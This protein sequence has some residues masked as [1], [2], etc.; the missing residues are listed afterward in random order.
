MGVERAMICSP[1]FDFGHKTPIERGFPASRIVLPIL[2][3][4][5]VKERKQETSPPKLLDEVIVNLYEQIEKEIFIP[6][7]RTRTKRQLTREFNN[8]FEEYFQLR[9]S[10]ISAF[11]SSM[12][13]E[14][15]TTRLLESAEKE[16]DSFFENE[17]KKYLGEDAALSVMFALETRKKFKNGFLE[18]INKGLIN[19][20][21]IEK[22]I[23]TLLHIEAFN[24]VLDL[25][26][27]SLILALRTK[28]TFDV[29]K[30]I[31]KELA[32]LSKMASTMLYSDAKKLE[33]IKYPKPK[34]TEPIEIMSDD[35]DKYLAE[36]G[37][38][39]Y[40]TIL[41]REEG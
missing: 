19:D 32:S 29:K 20:D 9:R 39:S 17:A 21:W 7:L 12:L 3:I 23:K 40:N 36:A 41:K 10:L 28:L 4:T 35:D 13:Q 27:C 11:S 16:I 22:N 24:A 2:D 6:I 34:S 33:I 15:R 14:K 1:S 38:K 18:A 30:T 26:E 25:C 31:L 8:K 5:E 37:L